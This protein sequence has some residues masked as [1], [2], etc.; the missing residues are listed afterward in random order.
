MLSND[1]LPSIEAPSSLLELKVSGL[2][3]TPAL[4][5]LLASLPKLQTLD[6]ERTYETHE[7]ATQKVVLTLPVTSTCLRYHLLL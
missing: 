6:L 7:K 2:I 3:K 1:A 5:S 4:A